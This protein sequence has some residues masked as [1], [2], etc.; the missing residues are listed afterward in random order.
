MKRFNKGARAYTRTLIHTAD[1]DKDIKI[2]T[3][4]LMLIDL[5]YCDNTIESISF[6][7]IG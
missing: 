4:A 7:N 5:I 6:I 1:R 3:T 2:G